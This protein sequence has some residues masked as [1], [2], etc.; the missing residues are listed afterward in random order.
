MKKTPRQLATF[1]AA[2]LIASGMALSSH[3]AVLVTDPGGLA[4]P[5]NSLNK[6]INASY[7][8]VSL[9]AANANVLDSGRAIHRYTFT[10]EVADGYTGAAYK[11]QDIRLTEGGSGLDMDVR[12]L[13]GANYFTLATDGNPVYFTSGS[14]AWLV[15]PQVADTT[16]RFSAGVDMVAFTM[17]RLQGPATVRVFSD[18]NAT[19]QIGSDYD[20]VANNNNFFGFE[21][22]NQAQIRAVTVS[23]AGVGGQY[24]MDDITFGM[25]IPEPS[26]TSLLFIGPLIIR[27][28]RRRR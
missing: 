24:S 4:K 27:L 20:L 23:F 26:T 22:L 16:L 13:S 8:N 3:A 6:T 2:T 11:N 17:N 10:G 9:A 1:T 7:G 12:F 25:Y 18:A 15:A 28:L 5:I 21:R 19:I 14:Q